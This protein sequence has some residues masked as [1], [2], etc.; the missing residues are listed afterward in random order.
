MQ[1]Y[2]VLMTMYK[3]D[4]PE[5]AKLAIESMLNQ[6]IKTNDF[7]LVCDGPLTLELEQLI[8][9]YERQNPEIFHVFRLEENVGLGGAL[10]YGVEKCK[11]ELIA[12]MDDDDISEKERCELQLKTFEEDVHLTICGSYMNEFEQDY[13]CPIREKR[14]PVLPEDIMVFSRRRNPF[15]HST[16][17]F[18]KTNILAV[19]NYSS[20]RTNQDVELWVRV[21]NN[22]Y[23][24]INIPKSLV[25][26][27]FDTATYKRRKN[28][29]NVKLMILVWHR[30]M[31]KGY[32]RK[33][34]F[35]YVLCLQIF[36]FLMPSRIIKWCYDT[37]R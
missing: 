23:R 7:V 13:C 20:M 22:G 26:F 33:R 27:R 29:K 18:K 3:N 14:V 25:N 37:F 6:T 24:G 28:W 2:S 5:Y 11:N 4:N 12:R 9:C 19:G 35:A 16:V 8:E 21:L 30:F 17:M 1:N 32:C 34:D 36:V 31:K 15:N 10:K